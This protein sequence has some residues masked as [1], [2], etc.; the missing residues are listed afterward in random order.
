M[1]LKKRIFSMLL[2]TVMCMTMGVSV[3]AATPE[4]F[5][6]ETVSETAVSLDGYEIMTID[7]SI[8]GYGQKTISSS[9]NGIIVQCTSSGAGG[10]GITIKTSCSA[11]TRKVDF[12]GGDPY[13]NLTTKITDGSMTTNDE[14]KYSNMWQNNCTT[15]LIAFDCPE[16]SPDF[17]VQV[18]IYG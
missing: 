13:N 12:I 5:E 9:S 16:G 14:V 1:K 8:S 3:S 2:A 10:M 4:S 7:S 6:N 17:L 11:G 15:Y 18:W